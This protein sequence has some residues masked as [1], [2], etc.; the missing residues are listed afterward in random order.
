MSRSVQAMIGP[1]TQINRTLTMTS[2]LPSKF[3]TTKH[4]IL[5]AYSGTTYRDALLSMRGHELTIVSAVGRS[6]DEIGLLRTLAE[7]NR[8]LTF[9][10]GT[11][12]CFT[13]PEFIKAGAKLAAELKN[14]E[15]VVDFRV[16]DSLHHKL[17]LISPGTVILGSS[18][19]TK[20]GLGG[21]TDL[22]GT[23]ADANMFAS[24]TSDLKRIRRQVGVLAAGATG[25]DAALR[26]Y[27][28]KAL[29]V[30]AIEHQKRIAGANTNPFKRG[31]TNNVTLSQWLISDEATP[32]WAFAYTRDLD[33]EEKTAAKE[34]RA[35]KSLGRGTGSLTTYSPEGKVFDGLFL[36]VSCIVA[37]RPKIWPSKVVTSGEFRG[38]RIVFGKRQPADAFGFVA[39][40][41][42]IKKLADLA[43]KY[44]ERW[45]TVAQMRKALG[46]ADPTP[47]Q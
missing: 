9:I 27:K 6:T 4:R 23:F 5:T 20:R 13:S 8:R 3:M 26:H 1:G 2:P 25:F 24:V 7:Q 47:L 11:Q 15:F 18:N 16:P 21:Q 45:L 41:E 12:N 17:T 42:E 35:E 30:G 38:T 32:L 46:T 33:Q 44:S 36:D 37:K 39:T 43:L 29:A 40:S 10:V 28:K 14:F 31:T 34:I 19:F 22:M